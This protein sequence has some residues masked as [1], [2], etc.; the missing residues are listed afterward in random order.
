MQPIIGLLHGFL[1]TS[2]NTLW[3]HYM[4]HFNVLHGKFSKAY[5]GEE[6]WT[7]DVVA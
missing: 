2:V 5:V 3:M 6:G 1:L 4:G 7:I